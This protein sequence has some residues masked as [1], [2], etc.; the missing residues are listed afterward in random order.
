LLQTVFYD[1]VREE[2]WEIVKEHKQPKID[3]RALQNF[4]IM[5]IKS[6]RSDLF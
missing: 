6:L 4:T 5:R 3:F 1:L 2:M